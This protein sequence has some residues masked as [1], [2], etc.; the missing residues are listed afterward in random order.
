MLLRGVSDTLGDSGRPWR[1]A[2]SPRTLPLELRVVG[3]L[4]E[5]DLNRRPLGY[6]YETAACYRVHGS[7]PRAPDLKSEIGRSRSSGTVVKQLG[8]LLD[9]I[10]GLELETV[11]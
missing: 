9:R 2:A 1:K 6:E 3:R 11:D 10:R 5:S 8:R 4:R 7:V